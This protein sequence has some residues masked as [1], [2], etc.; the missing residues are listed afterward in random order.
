MTPVTALPRRSLGGCGGGGLGLTSVLAAITAVALLGELLG[1]IGVA[2]AHA[3]CNNASDDTE[4]LRGM[5]PLD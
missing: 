5:V 4:I 2:A 3:K 1:P